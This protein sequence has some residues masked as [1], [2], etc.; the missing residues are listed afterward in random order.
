MRILLIDAG[1][2]R[3][4]WATMDRDN[5]VEPLIEKETN[6]QATNQ[7]A[8]IYGNKTPI[9]C[10]AD[11][12]KKEGCKQYK[13]V[14]LVSVQGKEFTKQAKKIASKA[15][16]GFFNVISPATFGSFKNGYAIPEQLGA[17]RF[18]AM[19]AAY[20]ISE[21]NNQSNSCI[22]IDC[23]T[24]VTLDAID[25]SGQH[26]GGLILPGLQVSSN[27]LL[28]STQQLFIAGKVTEQG[29]NQKQQTFNL[30]ADNTSDAIISGSFYGLSSAIKETCSRIEKQIAQSQPV[31]K[32]IC[33]GDAKLLLP[34][35]PDDYLM[36]TDLVLQGLE[37]VAKHT[38]KNNTK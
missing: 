24:A 10:Y 27:S 4:K 9:E 38:F 32:I 3:L 23:G 26:L 20:E 15:G 14:A 29:K 8:I 33:G 12:I 21:V 18:V 28:K 34:E 7:K 1:N 31:T 30:L 37:W 2:T 13:Q 19:L 17:D 22:I 25:A 35:L 11:L 36:H 6:Q 5:G 16:L